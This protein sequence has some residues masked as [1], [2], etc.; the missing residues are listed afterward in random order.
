MPGV[1]QTRIEKVVLEPGSSSAYSCFGTWENLSC[2][3]PLASDASNPLMGCSQA[4]ECRVFTMEKNPPTTRFQAKPRRD[5]R[6]EIQQFRDFIQEHDSYK[7]DIEP[8]QIVVTYPGDRKVPKSKR[9]F[10]HTKHVLDA[11]L[12]LEKD[13]ELIVSLE[14]MLVRQ[15]GTK[16]RR[17]DEGGPTAPRGEED[18]E[19]RR[20]RIAE[21][22]RQKAAANLT[23]DGDDELDLDIDIDIDID[24]DLDDEI[25]A[26]VA[27]VE[28]ESDIEIEDEG[29]GEELAIDDVE[30][31]AEDEGIDFASDLD[32]D[33]F[34]AEEEDDDGEDGDAESAEDG[35][36]AASDESDAKKKSGAKK[37]AGK[38]AKK[39][40]ADAPDAADKPAAKKAEKKPAAKK[41]EKKP[42]AKKAAKKK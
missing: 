23:D 32:P 5:G 3:Q 33:E 28:I 11:E 17:D 1:P 35:D 10:L 27:S 22:L 9:F 31:G 29:D 13:L 25:D 14:R 6:F 21:K 26:P 8:G 12:L 2:C 30:T 4:F 20:Q 16:K 37:A 15:A 40:D 24:I 41:A 19:A 42:A 38:K 18:A 39:K 34:G 7:M 36:N